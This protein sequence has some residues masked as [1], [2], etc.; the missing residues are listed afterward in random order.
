ME[1]AG[2]SPSAPEKAPPSEPRRPPL[3]RAELGRRYGVIGVWIVMIIGFSIAR[4]DTFATWGN[5]TTIA[6]SQAVLVIVTLALLFPLAASEFDLSI[7]GTL[8]LA[9]VLVGWL[10]VVH[11]WAILPTIAVAL[12]AGLIVGAVNAFF[13]VVIDVE[14]IV[15]TLGTGTFLGGLALAINQTS[16][17]GVSEDLVNAVQHP[18]LGIP[19][20]FYYGLALTLICWYVFSCTPFGR[21]L[22]FVGANRNVARL[23]GVRV[24]R[25]RILVFLLSG[26]LSALAGVVLAGSLGAADPTISNSYL[27]PAF[28]AAFLGSSV[29][30]PGRF[31]P[32]GSLIAVYFLVTGITGLELLGL[33]GWI[34]QIFYGT[35]LV[36]AVAISRLASRRRAS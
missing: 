22:Y 21:Y 12:A 3:D 29:I 16:I 26:F 15:V 34:E 25:M 7:S 13:V 1:I 30:V 2:S 11:E 20:L 6:S 14:S 33:S 9:L 27:L 35:S 5:V 32:I 8:G 4:P 23:A 18:L 36:L 31:N 24:A 19:A 28:A 17:G 10:N